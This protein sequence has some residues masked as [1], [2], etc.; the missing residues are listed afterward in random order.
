LAAALDEALRANFHYD[1][2]RR[3]GQLQALRLFRL[4]GRPQEEYLEE[5]VRRGQRLGDIKP[6]LLHLQG[7]WDQVFEGEYIN[8]DSFSGSSRGDAQ[9]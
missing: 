4:C 1:Y 9:V 6:V 7:G 3:L 8:E 5:C 2:C